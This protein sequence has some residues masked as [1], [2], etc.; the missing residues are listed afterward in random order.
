MIIVTLSTSFCIL[1][2]SRYCEI[3][4]HDHRQVSLIMY[5]LV[6]LL[7]VSL[8]VPSTCFSFS[9]SGSDPQCLSSFFN[10][11]S[12]LGS[13]LGNDSTVSSQN[14]V[15]NNGSACAAMTLL[16]ARGTAEPGK[17]ESSFRISL[18]LLSYMSGH[19][20]QCKY[21]K[22]FHGVRSDTG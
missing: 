14:G 3:S 15:T 21:L 22:M 18:F 9:C 13:L 8:S 20:V 12:I 11:S 16:F 7:A 19:Q 17:P 6:F 1:S 4:A 2:H 10:S 5:L